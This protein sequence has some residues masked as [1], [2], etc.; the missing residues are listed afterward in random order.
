VCLNRKKYDNPGHQ[1]LLFCKKK[2]K[3]KV[4]RNKN[5]FTLAACSVK[6]IVR[7]SNAFFFFIF[8]LQ[9]ISYWN[10]QNQ[11]IVN[12]SH[13]VLLCSVQQK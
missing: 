13:Q 4:F 9:I 3:K 7:S 6:I 12:V 1:L 5:G 10:E 8:L 11:F 2:K